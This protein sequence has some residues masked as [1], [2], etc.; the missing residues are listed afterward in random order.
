MDPAEDWRS[1]G[2]K[3]GDVCE[4]N[5]LGVMRYKDSKRCIN[6]RLALDGYM[7]GIFYL[8]RGKTKR[9]SQH[10]ALA[11]THLFNPDPIN[12]TTV[13]H[14]NRDKCD[15]RLENL[16]WATKSEQ[17][18]NQTRKEHYDGYRV[19]KFDENMNELDKWLSPVIAAKAIGVHRSSIEHKC[20]EGAFWRG[21]YWFYT[22]TF[23]LVAEMWVRCRD[24][25]SFAW[26]SNHGRVRRGMNGVPTYG[27]LSG[28]YFNTSF[29]VYDAQGEK[30]QNFFRMHFLTL[31]G[32][33]GTEVGKFANHVN[34]TKTDN[35]LCNLEWLTQSENV[36]HAHDT[37]LN[38]GCG[39]VVLKCLPD[40]TEI[41][42]WKSV[43]AAARQEGVYHNA[44]RGRIA[45]GKPVK[46][47]IWKKLA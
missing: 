47:F 4:V 7:I 14:I 6:W 19:G 12:R 27:Y 16:R 21:G 31:S 37:G 45:R 10:R 39:H 30:S 25:L 13:D 36:K 44:I 26:V 28:G 11:L 46:G 33:E 15:N 24:E 9:V 32:F 42:R 20:E 43:L 23:P 2:G 41:A 38:P 18:C 17:R 35:R 22:D 40:G 34:G 3:Y 1:L 29:A 5:G 8:C